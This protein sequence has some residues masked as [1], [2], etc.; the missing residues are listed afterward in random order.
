M[1]W[2]RVLFFP[3]LLTNL[4]APPFTYFFLPTKQQNYNAGELLCLESSP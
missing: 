4:N 2:K 3:R 1:G